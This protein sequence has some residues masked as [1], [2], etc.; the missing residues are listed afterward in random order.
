MA[1]NQDHIFFIADLLEGCVEFPD[2]LNR[3]LVIPIDRIYNNHVQPS[4]MLSI[5]GRLIDHF[6]LNTKEALYWLRWIGSANINLI[7]AVYIALLPLT[8]TQHREQ[9]EQLE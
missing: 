6:N 7:L 4:E 1:H 5:L 2:V 8:R 9:I 3:F